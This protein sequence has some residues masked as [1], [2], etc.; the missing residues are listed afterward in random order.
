MTDL[1]TDDLELIARIRGDFAERT[2]N[3]EFDEL[4]LRPRPNAV[5]RAH[6]E[7]STHWPARLTVAALLV[8]SVAGLA[9]LAG[10]RTVVDSSAQLTHP[11]AATNPSV[12][13][14]AMTS[15][16]NSSVAPPEAAVSVASVVTR[17]SIDSPV[18]SRLQPI[19]ELR[20]SAIDLDYVILPRSG[21]DA[22]AAGVGHDPSSAALGALGNAVLV[23]HRTTHFAPFFS[24]DRLTPGDEIDVTTTSGGVFVYTVT[25][26]VS[27]DP[28]DTQAIASDPSK[29]TLSLVTCTPIGTSS[30]RLVVHAAL[31]SA[32]SSQPADARE[33]ASSE[34]AEVSVCGISA[35][36]P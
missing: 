24:L 31:D 16:T 21:D 19:G 4:P 8:A 23:G 33:V 6:I 29:A 30:H 34:T 14:T 17:D 25:D 18:T 22:L 1:D 28:N 26:S 13:D 36:T 32:R 20:I 10:R 35:G 27:T 3:V 11:F 15:V 7:R 5:R 2:C 12:P 9:L